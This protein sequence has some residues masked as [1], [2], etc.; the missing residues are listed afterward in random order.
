MTTR[1]LDDAVVRLVLP[2][3]AG[4]LELALQVVEW[5]MTVY[6]FIDDQQD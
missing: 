6:S 1:L 4:R 2:I 5:K 3:N